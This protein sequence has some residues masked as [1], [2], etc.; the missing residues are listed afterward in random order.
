M[1]PVRSLGGPGV[2]GGGR[3]WVGGRGDVEVVVLDVVLL[4]VAGLGVGCAV[5]PALERAVNAVLAA[6][7][8]LGVTA[9]LVRVGYRWVRERMEDRAD[10]AYAAQ[11]RAARSTPDRPPVR[12]RAGLRGLPAAGSPVVVGSTGRGGG[13]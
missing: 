8:V 9:V 10:A 5:S 4:V 1:S 11:V 2:A 12:P 13:R 3:W 7:V 6:V